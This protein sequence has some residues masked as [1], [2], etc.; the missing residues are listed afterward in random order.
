MQQGDTLGKACAVDAVRQ[1]D[2]HPAVDQGFLDVLHGRALVA[3]SDGVQNE[4][5]RNRRV[6][7]EQRVNERL[8]I[9]AS[10][11]SHRSAKRLGGADSIFVKRLV[12]VGVHVAKPTEAAFHA[13]DLAA[14]I[15]SPDILKVRRI[16]GIVQCQQGHRRRFAGRLNA[17]GLGPPLG[18]QVLLKAGDR[19][20][21]LCPVAAVGLCAKEAVLNQLILE[22]DH[23]IAL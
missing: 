3:I 14:L 7:V 4:V 16:I 17:Q 21:S 9:G 10:L 23:L 12:R 15:P 2:G 6:H 22:G 5:I 8:V 20:G 1:A 18:L 19:R 11:Y 13:Q